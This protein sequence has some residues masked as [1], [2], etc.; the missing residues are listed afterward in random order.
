MI[1]QRK[2]DLAQIQKLIAQGYYNGHVPITGAICFVSSLVCYLYGYSSIIT[3]L[4]KSADF[5]NTEYCGM[6]IN[7]QWSKSQTFQAAL[8]EYFHKFI[9]ENLICKSL[10]SQRYE[11]KIIQE[12]SKFPQYFKAF[13]SCNRNFH[14]ENSQLS[15]KQL[16]CGVCPKCAFVYTLLR[17]FL[18]IEQ[19]NEI[20]GQNLF[21]KDDLLPLF[22]ELMGIDGIKPFECVGTNEEMIL[23]LWLI[24][25]KEEQKESPIMQLF[26]DEILAKMEAQEFYTLEKKLLE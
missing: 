7:H 11:I 25:K 10:L 13:S 1:I 15:T 17:A 14:I 2:L 22:K 26:I 16:W 9:A 24:W 5:G 21:E 3:S 20:F 8:Q 12:F 23:A 6:E 18:E 4:E 19:V